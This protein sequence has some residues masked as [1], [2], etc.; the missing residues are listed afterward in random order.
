M[1]ENYLLQELVTFAQAGTLAK[2]AAKLHVTQPTVTRGMQKLEDE[3]GVKLFERQPNKLELTKTGKLAAKKAATLLQANQQFMNEI[4]DFSQS[5]QVLNIACVAPGPQIVIRQAANQLPKKVKLDQQLL[6]TDQVAT[7]LLNHQYS[8][9]ITN[10]E[11]QTNLIESYY[12]GQEHLFVNLDQFMYLA[13]QQTVTF[14]ELRG[15]SFVVLNEIGPWKQVIQKHIP[16][17]K[18]LYQAEYDAL[19]ELTKYTSFPFFTTNITS[20]EVPYDTTDTVTI[21]ITDDAATMTFYAAYLK[22]QRKAI[23]PVAKKLVDIWP[24]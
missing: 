4:R 8:M 6:P 1:I 13:N 10:H 20:P 18:F 2:T 17:A 12:L 7:S 15:L 16:N 21:P 24:K 9:L 11:I 14:T 3:L 23:I 22:S 5:Q 19:N